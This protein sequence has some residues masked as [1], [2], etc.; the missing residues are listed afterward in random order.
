LRAAIE[1]R[2]SQFSGAEGELDAEMVAIARA[3]IA[4]RTG[5]FDP[6]TNRARSQRLRRLSI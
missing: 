3:I 1:V 6:T 4:P 5:T 2:A